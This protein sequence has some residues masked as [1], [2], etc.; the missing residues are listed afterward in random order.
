MMYEQSSASA[1]VVFFSLQC[2][3][4]RLL[5]AKRKS[6]VTSYRNFKLVLKTVEVKRT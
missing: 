6:D 4:F 1:Q 3:M 5:E 2:L